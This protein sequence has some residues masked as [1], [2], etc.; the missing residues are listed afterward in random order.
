MPRLFVPQSQLPFITGSDAHY[1][2]DV[3][4]LKAGDELEL[5]DGSGLV[6]LSRVKKIEKDRI[7]TE[8]ISEKKS[9]SE[10]STKITL[11]QALPKGHKMDFIIEKCV[12]L[13]VSAIIPVLTERTIGKAAKL[14][15]WQKLAKE[16]AEQS[17]RAIVPAIDP[18]MT[19]DEVLKLKSHYN[20]SLIPWELEKEYTLKKHFT[21]HPV[22]GS[23]DI[24]L[25]IGPEGGFSQ[26]EVAA[27]K[28]AGFTSISLGKRILR[29]ETAGMATIAAIN[30]EEGDPP[31]KVS[32]FS[33]KIKVP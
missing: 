23:P 14:E 18:L 12:E 7:L 1:L 31:L 19:F 6:Y 22:T 32:M 4:R 17:G 33:L 26:K 25:L 21:D 20:L 10:P 11:A 29:T 24:L 27:A 8:I 9:E 15:R 13:G 3:M 2:K 30:Y 28:K 5:F 16:A